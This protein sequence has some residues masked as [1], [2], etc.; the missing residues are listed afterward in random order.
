VYRDL[1]LET[2]E[3]LLSDVIR[4]LG[5]LAEQERSFGAEGAPDT[6]DIR[7]LVGQID[8]SESLVIQQMRRELRM[9]GKALETERAYVGWVDRFLRYCGV[10]ALREKESDASEAVAV[11]D[12]SALSDAARDALQL[13]RVSRMMQSLGEAEMRSFLTSLAVE[14]NVAPNTQNQ[15]KS[16][17]LFLFQHVL[18]REVGFLDIVS[19][20]KP[21]RLPVVLSRQEIARLLPEFQAIRRLK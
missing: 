18:S 6:R 12:E 2:E 14:G 7:K 15:A 21:E 8:S 11:V 17:L 20:D 5:Q 19:A 3:P 10:T 13:Q 9:Q 1:I 16:A 4:K